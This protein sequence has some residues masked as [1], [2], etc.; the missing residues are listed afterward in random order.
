MNYADYPVTWLRWESNLFWKSGHRHPEP[1]KRIQ[2]VEKLTDQRLLVEV[3]CTDGSS[4]VRLA[5]A[6]KIEGDP[7]LAEV[8]RNAQ[9]LD[10]RLAAVERISSQELLA[11]IIKTRKNYELMGACFSRITDK[12]VLEAIAEDTGY[13]PAARRIAVEQFADESYLADLA[14]PDTRSAPDRDPDM[15]PD[16]GN[17]ADADDPPGESNVD[18]LLE[19][20][21]NVRVVRAI[22]RFRHSEKAVSA[23]GK[24]A[25]KGGESAMLAIDYLCRALGSS[26][27]SVH[28]RAFNEL[29]NLTNPSLVPCLIR[30]MDE[31]KLNKPI[32]EVLKKIGT[33]E[34]IAAIGENQDDKR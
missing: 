30:A 16:M 1:E 5:A 18:T 22:G 14:G 4:R 7:D 25:R 2:A 29:T 10:V 19:M 15:G 21:G 32:K 11:H 27:E 20:Y 24:I 8:A 12:N 17:E 34:A 6:G 9:E 13:N 33:P 31:P 26:N 28:N 3:A 23:L